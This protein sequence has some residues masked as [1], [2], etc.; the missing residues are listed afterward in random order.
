MV[1]A[2][3]YQAELGFQVRIQ[4]PPPPFTFF[5]L[6]LLSPFFSLYFFSLIFY[7]FFF[8]FF[9]HL[10][11][12]SFFLL[13][14]FLPSFSS[15]PFPTSIFYLFTPLLTLIPFF[16]PPPPPS[17]SLPFL[18]STIFPFLLVFLTPLFPIFFFPPFFPF[19]FLLSHIFF[20]FLPHLFQIDNKM[21]FLVKLGNTFPGMYILSVCMSGMYLKTHLHCSLISHTFL[22]GSGV[23]IRPNPPLDGG[24]GGE[25]HTTKSHSVRVLPLQF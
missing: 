2:E 12:S 17:L 19:L 1:K 5:L 3:I 18:L 13:P 6:F 9:Y 16:F 22:E 8:H 7:P 14:L 20:L 10:F 21:A 25:A 15:P 4:A 23:C 24:G 11:F